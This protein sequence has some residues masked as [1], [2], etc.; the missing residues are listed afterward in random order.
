M[1][2]TK[3]VLLNA[4]NMETY[5]VYPYAFIQVPAIARR[6][7]IEVVCKDLLGVPQATVVNWGQP[8]HTS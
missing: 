2:N 1:S 7:G 5:P 3:M 4:S 6:V 8:G